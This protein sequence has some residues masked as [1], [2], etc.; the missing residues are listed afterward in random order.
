[1]LFFNVLKFVNMRVFL[2]IL[3]LFSL[4]FGNF[5]F[6]IANNNGMMSTFAN[7][8]FSGMNGIV[9]TY[10]VESPQEENF[11]GIRT[12]IE[13]LHESLS[14]GLNGIMD[15][16]DPKTDSVISEQILVK[17]SVVTPP[18]KYTF[19]FDVNSSQLKKS[20]ID[21]I[22]QYL[23]KYKEANLNHIVI[24][25]YADPSGSSNYNLSLSQKRAISL[26]NILVKS[27]IPAQVILIE[28]L[29]EEVE[30]RDYAH[31][32]RAEL[33]FTLVK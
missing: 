29:G 16:I 23:S 20:D 14:N 15:V 10:H 11:N 21:L 25:G 5:L 7:T 31:S 3:L 2:N 13:P 19:H 28:A 32:R 9:E 26:K 8:E 30:S 24:K 4:L 22:Q 18:L 33:I 12:E 6:V 17:R 27:G 1:M